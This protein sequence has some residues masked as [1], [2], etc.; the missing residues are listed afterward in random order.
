M[1]H[2]NRGSKFTFDNFEVTKSNSSA[3][4]KVKHFAEML[5]PSR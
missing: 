1:Q 2:T 3:F 4:E 5:I